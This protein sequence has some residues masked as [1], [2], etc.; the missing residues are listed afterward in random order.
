MARSPAAERRIRIGYVIGQLTRGGAE[1]QLYELVRSINHDRVECVVYCLSDRTDPF[2]DMIAAAGV[3]VT[4]L[5]R[6][7]RNRHTRILGLARHA[8]QDRI[9]ILHAFLGHASGYAWVARYLAGAPRLITSARNC[10]RLGFFRDWPLTLA[11]R[12]SDAIECNAEAVRAFVVS[13]YGAPAAKC[14]VIHNSVDITRFAPPPQSSSAWKG[15]STPTVMTVCR[16]V[17]QKDLGL[18]LEAARLLTTSG[19]ATRFLVVGNGRGRGGLVRMA[20]ELGLGN[21]VEFLGERADVPDL[22]RGADVFWL[23][24]SWEGLP[25]VLLEAQA[26][27]VPVVA[28]DAGGAREAMRDGVTG[29]IVADRDAAAFASHTRDLLTDLDK[30]RTMGVAGRRLMEGCFSIAARMRAIERLYETVLRPR[31]SQLEPGPDLPIA[32]A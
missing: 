6:S 14:H 30:A 27:G 1:R 26:T 7:T 20:A 4:V 22:L 9:D 10:K 12:S 32:E 19:P 3:K 23:T 25:N 5:P 17:A 11:Y 28:R 29:Y 2:G 21:A 24:S 13:Q 8:R 16:L 18:F 15:G 31:S